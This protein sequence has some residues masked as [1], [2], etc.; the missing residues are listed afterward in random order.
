MSHLS[1]TRLAFVLAFVVGLG[2]FALDAYLPAFAAIAQDFGRTTPEV[3]L[4]VGTYVIALAAGQL[5]GGP[6]SDRFGRA[7]VMFCGL[8]IFLFGSLA[9]A[10]S[11]TLPGML[12]GRVV[13]GFG[14]GCST[15]G[16]PAIVR[17]RTEGNETAR[18]FSLVAMIMFAAPAIAPSL[19][20]L[21]LTVGGWRSVFVFLALYAITAAVLARWALFP[22]GGARERRSGTEPLHRLVTNYGLVLRHRRTM[23]FIA[24]QALASS[25]MMVYLTHAPF[26]YQEWLGFST[27]TFSALFALN[28]AVMMGFSVSNRRLLKRHAFTDL[29]SLAIVIQA[30]GIVLLAAIA[31]LELP[32]LLA[33]PALAL[34][35]GSMG[36]IGPNNMAGA[37]HSFR[38]LAGTAAALM[39]AVQFATGGV[40][41]AVSVAL[42]FT[43]LLDMVVAMAAC[44]V[45]ALALLT[46]AR[47]AAGRRAAAARSEP[48]EE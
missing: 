10:A 15:V 16:V 7:R 35:I 6:L 25:V 23:T 11:D 28:V 5:I 26:V 30:G 43:E 31:V 21:L 42:P 2:P 32:G 44:S 41:A 19:G 47:R 48:V 1:H 17:D 13:Q 9:I 34:V 40:V 46:A 37:L 39:G 20:A 27:A 33:V 24:L 36:A 22:P 3:G 8:A 12:L 14:G 4:T 29:L 18:L 45:C 38:I